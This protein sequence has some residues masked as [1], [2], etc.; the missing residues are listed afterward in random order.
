VTSRA[1]LGGNDYIDWGQLP[2]SITPV[3]TPLSVVSNGGLGATL[4][5]SQGAVFSDQQGNPWNGNFAPGDHLVGTGDVTP[6][7]PIEI[8][9]ATPVRGVGAQMGFD[10]IAAPGSPYYFT[11]VLTLYDSAHNQIGQFVA[12][13]VMDTANDN[14][15]VFIGALD[16]TAD[17][18]YAEFNALPEGPG[19]AINRLDFVTAAAVP[20]PDSLALL[21][22]S[23]LGFG[24]LGRRKTRLAAVG[25]SV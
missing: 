16:S 23:A 10:I 7:A 8:T 25:R 13:G 3:P 2:P 17:I 5:N 21:A 9:F 11:E 18:K 22:A 12:A 6:F 15:A 14:S 1:A 20:E 24:A 19:F 4:G